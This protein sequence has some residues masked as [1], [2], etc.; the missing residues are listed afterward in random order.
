MINPAG[1]KAHKAS[2]DSFQ[3]SA[4]SFQLKIPESLLNADSG[5]LTAFSYSLNP[6]HPKVRKA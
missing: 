5:L 1:P 3:L 2:K 6:N 4:L